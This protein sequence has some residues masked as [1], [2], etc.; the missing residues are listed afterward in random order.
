MGKGKE[1]FIP[2]ECF[3]IKERLGHHLAYPFQVSFA[4]ND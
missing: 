1:V 3:L 2:S 4:G